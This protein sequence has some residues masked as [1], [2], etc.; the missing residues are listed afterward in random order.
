MSAQHESFI[1]CKPITFLGMLRFVW[2][3]WTVLLLSRPI[4]AQVDSLNLNRDYLNSYWQNSRHLVTAPVRW[5]GKQLLTFASLGGI[6]VAISAADRNVSTFFQE[7]QTVGLSR[8]STYGLEP[9]ANYYAFFTIGALMV[10][11]LTN[12]N[13]KG[14]ATAM[15]AIQ[16]YLIS[17]LLVKAPKYLFG[18]I[19]PNAWWDPEPNEWYGPGN[20]KSFPSGHTTS[21]FSVASVVAYQY[22]DKPWIPIASYGL[23]TLVG[24]SRLY[25]NKHWVSDVFAGAVLG[26]VTGYFICRQHE[27]QMVQIV[28]VAGDDVYGLQAT[29]SW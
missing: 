11:G 14:S 10:H 29:I 20:G 22:R 5:N 25:D 3:F 18:R 23:A 6:T 1:A 24:V 19:R 16:S 12:D 17:G 2:I 9:L 8:V 15:M 21:A 27:K 4:S 7:N 28:P 26:T 13:N